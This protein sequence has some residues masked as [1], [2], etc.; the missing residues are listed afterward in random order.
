L[1]DIAYALEYAADTTRQSALNL[2]YLLAFQPD[3]TS[4]SIYGESDERFHIRGGNQQL[5]ARMAA[6]L[7]EAVRSGHRLARIAE[8]AG[9][10]Y[11][12]TFE[13]GGGSSEVVA[14]HVVLALPFAV[15]RELDFRDAG[16]DA[17]KRTAI[18]D[19]GRGRVAKL[20]VQFDRRPWNQNGPWPGR[21]NGSSYSDTGYQATWEFSRAQPGRAG[22]LVFFSGGSAADRAATRSPF[23]TID[24]PGV[25]ADVQRALG[26]I[27]P[28]FP[29]LPARWNGRAT[30]SLPH[31]SP[32]F[33]SAYAF[34]AP[35]QYTEF[36]GYE[37]VRQGGV[38]FCGEHPTTD[39]QGFM[40]G[41]A[42]EG[43]RAARQ[44]ARII[45][46]VDDGDAGFE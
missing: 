1:L 32:F 14:D 13:R 11:R 41:G 39:F 29:G 27:A 21:S 3:E 37:K 43:R 10:R 5:P 15:L 35:G 28:V 34:Y 22:G 23:A 36:G 45:D 38:L 7:G 26:Q 6:S 18:R 30:Q 19:L 2:L 42:S 33:R 40:E 12:L 16:F 44:L 8:T 31:E 24:Q 25:R 46:G 9:G 17:M 4:L 20:N